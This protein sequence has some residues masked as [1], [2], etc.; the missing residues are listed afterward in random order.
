MEILDNTLS[1]AITTPG[2]TPDLKWFSELGSQVAGWLEKPLASAGQLL[3]NMKDGAVELWKSIRNGSFGKIFRQWAKDDPVGA[4]AGVAAAGLAAGTML[5]VGGQAIGWVVG[6]AG[7]VLGKVGILGKV[8]GA[9]GLGG[10]AEKVLNT[11]ETIYRLDFNQS[12]ESIMQEIN[13]S[14]NNLYEPAGEF[15]G[16]QIAA[17]VAGGATEPP[18]VEINVKALSLAWALNP[19]IR[20]DL[21]DNVSELAYL[22]MQTFSEIGIKLALMHGRRGIKKLWEKSPESIKKLIPG[23]GKKIENWGETGSE[24]WTI[25]SAVNEQ[26]EKISDERIQN[27]VQG[28]LSGFWEQFGNSVQ[29]VYN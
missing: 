8:G 6:S 17:I 25:E 1:S 26:V 27:V 15:L 28:L 14:I 16:K 11:A 12:D 19:E 22:G 3:K 23:I 4:A 9:I 10:A 24:P 18:K 13:Q 20:Q 21:L 7:S 5:I 29:Y 2:L